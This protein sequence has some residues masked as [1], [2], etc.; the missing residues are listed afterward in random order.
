MKG[1]LNM[2]LDR[3]FSVEV[4]LDHQLEGRLKKYPVIVLPEWT[5]IDPAVKIKLLDYVQ[6]GGNL[7]IAGASASA[8][9]AEPLG[10][11]LMGPTEKDTSFFASSN[12]QVLHI[13]TAFQPIAPHSETTVLGLQ[14]KSDD[15]RFPGSFPLASVANYGKGK[16]AAIY[17]D[18]GERYNSDRNT[19]SANLLQR[20]IHVLVPRFAA[21][22]NG[23]YA[24]HQV[25]A[26]KNGHLYI[27][28]INAGGAHSNP[29]VLDYAK[30]NPLH[31]IEVTLQL[32]HAPKAIRLQPENKSL[33]FTYTNGL[34]NVT[35]P[36][37]AVYSILE[38]E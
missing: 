6:Q 7:L 3:Q 33:S 19:F 26:W 4:L 9:F 28:L 27:H 12:E 14:L 11:S 29:S 37:L 32:A 34:A 8:V 18:P 38:I 1:V 10:V 30:V 36:E 23:S 22:V 5:G 21:S 31:N 15:L 2:L 24:V 13:R 35:V 17:F 16:I 20:V 25:T